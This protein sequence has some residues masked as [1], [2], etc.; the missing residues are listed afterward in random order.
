MASITVNGTLPP[1]VDTPRAELNSYLASL[2]PAELANMIAASSDAV[3]RHCR[4]NFSVAAYT[5]LFDGGAYPF[6]VLFLPEPPVVSVARLATNPTTVLTIRNT[7][8]ANQ[9]ATVAVTSTGL[10]LV[11]VASGVPNTDSTVTFAAN[12]TVQALCNAVN[13]L[14]NGWLAAPV[15]GYE[16]YPSADLKVTQG[17]FNAIGN[18][19]AELQIHIEEPNFG[20]T[21]VFMDGL[22]GWTVA[23]G[24]RLD[25]SR[26]IIWGTFFPSPLGVRVDWAGGFTSVPDAVQEATVLTAIAISR[27]K[28]LNPTVQSASLGAASFTF[29]QRRSAIPPEAIA[30]LSNYVDWAASRI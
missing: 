5:G 1:L 27:A 3:R 30:L 6:D 2:D 7:S 26:A 21:G 29:A 25:E 11:R 17:A 13:A 23:S 19:G 16:L 28:K 4:R 14:G 8:S 12:V 22:P 20:G 15:T 10:T 18:S 9:R 24:W